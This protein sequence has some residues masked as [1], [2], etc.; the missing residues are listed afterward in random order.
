MLS[1][2]VIRKLKALKYEHAWIEHLQDLQKSSEALM[3]G[4]RSRQKSNVQKAITARDADR[5]SEVRQLHNFSSIYLSDDD[6]SVSVRDGYTGTRRGQRG[7]SDN[8][9]ILATI[10]IISNSPYRLIIS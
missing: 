6:N 3:A 4:L 9:P 1:A 7:C 5:H 2:K 10:R 8:Q